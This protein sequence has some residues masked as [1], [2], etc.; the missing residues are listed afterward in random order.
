MIKINYE[1][2]IV[3]FDNVFDVKAF[4]ALPK[5]VQLNKAGDA[6]DGRSR[7]VKV[8]KKD[9]LVSFERKTYKKRKKSY[10]H[11]WTNDEIDSLIE[12]LEAGG[13]G[14]SVSYMPVFSKHSKGAIKQMAYKILHNST[15]GMSPYMKQQTMEFNSRR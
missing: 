14:T 12:T 7:M 10:P 1:G 13:T 8:D 6:L 5:G 11:P 3:E 15:T 2:T 4:L 9:A